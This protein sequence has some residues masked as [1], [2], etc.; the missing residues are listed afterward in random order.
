MKEII[1]R[2]RL[3]IMKKMRKKNNRANFLH[4]IQALDEVK[5][6]LLFDYPNLDLKEVLV[7]AN[8]IEGYDFLFF[9]YN[10]KV[11]KVLVVGE[12]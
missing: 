7:H 11:I 9:K 4:L 6:E 5:G 10:D 8:R 2:R 3:R 12:V 1:I